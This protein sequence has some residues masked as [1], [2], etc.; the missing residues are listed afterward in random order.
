VGVWSEAA[1]G[2]LAARHPTA[3]CD[4][5]LCAGYAPGDVVKQNIR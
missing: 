3:Q 1:S 4:A 5:G 2:R